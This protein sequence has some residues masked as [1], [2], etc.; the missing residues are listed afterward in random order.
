MA[1]RMFPTRSCTA[2]SRTASAPVSRSSGELATGT[3]GATLR[4]YLEHFEPDP[5]R[6][7]EDTQ[8]TLAGLI[9]YAE[10]VAGIKERT[11]RDA[12]TVIT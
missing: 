12:P 11:G 5:A 10:H 4:V 7:E 2:A 3:S 8:K 1:A 6:H 9:A